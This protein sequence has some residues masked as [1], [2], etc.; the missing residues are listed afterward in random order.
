MHLCIARREIERSPRGSVVWIRETGASAAAKLMDKLAGR[1]DFIFI[2]GDHTYKGLEGDWLG[3]SPL[4]APNGITA[5]HDSRS[6]TER[7]IDQ[8][9]SVIFTQKVISADSRFETVATVDS[10]T[11]LRRK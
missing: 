4:I 2:D 3:W 10:L 1:V 8:A 5:L 11:V 6:T 7:P 9:G